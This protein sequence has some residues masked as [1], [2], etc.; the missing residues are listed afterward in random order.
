MWSSSDDHDN[1]WSPW[2]Q[3][4]ASRFFSSD[5]VTSHGVSDEL[6]HREGSG[7]PVQ[8]SDGAE[9]A[10][11]EVQAAKE[12]ATVRAPAQRILSDRASRGSSLQGSPLALTRSN[13]GHRLP[14]CA[15]YVSPRDVR[16]RGACF[17]RQRDSLFEI[18]PSSQWAEIIKMA[19][20]FGRGQTYMACRELSELIATEDID[21]TPP[22]PE[23]AHLKVTR[24][25]NPTV[26]GYYKRESL[27]QYIQIQHED[28]RRLKRE[29]A[30]HFEYY[31]GEYGYWHGCR[32]QQWKLLN[33]TLPQPWPG[34]DKVIAYST[35]TFQG[36]VNDPE[37]PPLGKD[38]WS[39]ELT[40]ELV[41]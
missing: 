8:R 26:N 1:T 37:R 5:P 29:D 15:G 24:A 18:V 31:M 16:P 3:E 2:L 30:S 21:I 41:S 28:G 17:L 14:R 32:G 27:G 10:R 7:P 39:G 12:A 25:A 19:D 9:D 13:S 33:P 4:S 11:D 34:Q 40:L 22:I 20:P 35:E 38:A 6:L 36:G 23:D